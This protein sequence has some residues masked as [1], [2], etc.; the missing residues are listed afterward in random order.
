[1]SKEEYKDCICKMIEETSDIEKL[2]NILAF[3]YGIFASMR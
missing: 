3:I 2:K 1:M